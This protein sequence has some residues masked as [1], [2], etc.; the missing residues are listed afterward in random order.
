[1]SFADCGWPGQLG[2]GEEVVEAEHAE[3]GRPLDEE[4][5]QIGGGEGVV[6]G[7]MARLVVEPE[8]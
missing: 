3:P 7:P 6:E 1:M 8:A 4:V 2:Q 5:E